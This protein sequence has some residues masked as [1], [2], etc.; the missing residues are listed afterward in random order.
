MDM[1]VYMYCALCSSRLCIYSPVYLYICTYC[2]L[3]S[4]VY[5][6]IARSIY[7]YVYIC[8]AHNVHPVYVYVCMYCAL[9]SSRLCIYSPVYPCTCIYMYGALYLCRD[10]QE[11]IIDS[12]PLPS[13]VAPNEGG[14]GKDFRDIPSLRKLPLG[15]KT[16]THPATP[17]LDILQRAPISQAESR[18]QEELSRAP[19]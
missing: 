6:F 2:A 17:S 10:T 13:P 19:Q 11:C 16:I 3:C 14:G 8:T 1:Y 4:S 7:V 18:D 12:A 15:R 5:V 9:C